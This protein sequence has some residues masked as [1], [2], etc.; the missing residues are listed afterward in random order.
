MSFLFSDWLL[1]I[2]MFWSHHFIFVSALWHRDRQHASVKMIKCIWT[3]AGFY[4][5]STMMKNS[6]LYLRLFTSLSL[7]PFFCRHV[8]LYLCVFI[9]LCPSHLLCLSALFVG[10]LEKPVDSEAIALTKAKT[11]YKSCTNE[12][13]LTGTRYHRTLFLYQPMS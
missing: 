3:T 8:D 7:S 10:V 6:T 1:C 13:E 9:C 5:Q 2:A 12:S 11:L 4:F